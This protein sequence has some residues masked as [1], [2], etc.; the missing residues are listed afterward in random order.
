[1]SPRTWVN[2]AKHP[3]GD[4]EIEEWVGGGE[5]PAQQDGGGNEERWGQRKAVPQQDQG[6]TAGGEA[7]QH[8]SGRFAQDARV[9]KGHR[10]SP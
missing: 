5:G 7:A 8:F 4:G 10:Q 1:M 6:R 3:E 2:P 9:I